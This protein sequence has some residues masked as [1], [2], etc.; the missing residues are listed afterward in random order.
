MAGVRFALGALC[1]LPGVAAS[2]SGASV[3]LATLEAIHH[4]ENPRNLTRPG[5][6]GELGPYQFRL[7]TWRM[8]TALPFSQ[9]IDREISDQVAV[10]HY[11]WLERGLVSARMPA[12]PYNIALAWNGG[13]SA[14]V[15]GR[16][17]R[18]AHRYAERAANLAASFNENRLVADAR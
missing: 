17:P 8:H 13:L 5:P 9:A 12:T 18:A 16:S 15:A 3:R 1:L 7:A 11:A 14:A 6:C 4:L 10:R 2:A